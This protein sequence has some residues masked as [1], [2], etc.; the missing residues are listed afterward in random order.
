MERRPKCL[1]QDLDQLNNSKTTR[2]KSITYIHVDL[3]RII[4]SVLMDT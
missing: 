2:C 3:T 4:R 1:D